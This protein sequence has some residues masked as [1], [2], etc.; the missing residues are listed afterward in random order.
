MA[1]M[2]KARKKKRKR[3]SKK[4]AKRQRKKGGGGD[5][6][7]PGVVECECVKGEKKK[8]ETDDDEIGCVNTSGGDR[9]AQRWGGRL[10]QGTL[11]Q[12]V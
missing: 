11:G 12:L 9:G 7:C 6:L 8:K 4:K 10:K 5:R 1:A 3:I 2:K